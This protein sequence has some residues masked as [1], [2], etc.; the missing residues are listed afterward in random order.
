MNDAEQKKFNF[1]VLRSLERPFYIKSNKIYE[2]TFNEVQLA[3]FTCKNEKQIMKIWYCIES[4]W[5]QFNE[6]NACT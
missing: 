3:C 6:K 5:S 2:N 4:E 1:D